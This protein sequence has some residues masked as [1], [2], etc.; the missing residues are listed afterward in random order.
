M[1]QRQTCNPRRYWEVE[2]NT[3][4]RLKEGQVEWREVPKHLIVRLSLFFDGRQWDLFGKEA[5]FVR[6]RA[7]EIPGI[8]ESF[9]LERRTIGFYEGSKKVSYNI[10][11]FTGKLTLEVVDNNGR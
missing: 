9:R 10:D 3:G 7:S 8:P 1:D 5:Y 11:E 2:L 6:Y 4:L